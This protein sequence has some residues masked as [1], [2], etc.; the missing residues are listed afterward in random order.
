MPDFFAEFFAQAQLG[1]HGLLDGCEQRDGLCAEIFV[2]G[3]FN[4]DR[5]AHAAAVF[6]REHGQVREGRENAG[7]AVPLEPWVLGRIGAHKEFALRG[8]GVEHMRRR[9]GRGA[10]VV[11]G[12][13]QAAAVVQKDRN[14]PGS[15]GFRAC[16]RECGVQH[17]FIHGSAR[18]ADQAVDEFQGLR[19]LLRESKGTSTGLRWRHSARRAEPDCSACPE[20]GA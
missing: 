16:L 4:A 15:G 18:G 13:E 9:Q 10:G 20:S 14:L 17:V 11:P 5:A 19:V 2:R 1:C 3:V 6:E 7:R 8:H 12:L